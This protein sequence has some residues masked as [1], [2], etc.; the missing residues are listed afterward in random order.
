MK[1]RAG[2]FGKTRSLETRDLIAV[3]VPRLTNP[4][5]LTDRYLF[6]NYNCPVLISPSFYAG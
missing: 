4:P 2:G 3:V 1:G 6:I 5:G